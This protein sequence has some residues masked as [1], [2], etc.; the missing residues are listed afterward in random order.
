M[1][2]DQAQEDFHNVFGRAFVAAYEQQV[3][4]IEG[5]RRRQRQKQ[6]S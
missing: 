3:D 1:I 5:E 4:R 6:Q 2:R